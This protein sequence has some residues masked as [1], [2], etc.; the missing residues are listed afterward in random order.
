MAGVAPL[1]VAPER[2]AAPSPAATPRPPIDEN[3]EALAALSDIVDGVVRFDITETREYVE[4]A[5]VG[6]DP[7]L[8]RRLRHGDFSWQSHLDLHGMT[9]DLARHEVERFLVQAVRDG[10]R[11]VLLVHGRGLNSKDRA[12]V[13]KERLKGW[14]AR[15][16]IGRHVLA[17][18]TA[19]AADG[20]AGA[21]YVLL[22]RDRRRRPIRVTEGTTR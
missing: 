20:G 5:I 14:L 13:L 22:R 12:P 19:R 1:P 17:F 16:T 10:V 3:A 7:R 18:T 8:V 21:V 4:G 9:A 2:I 11:C 6:L 15:G